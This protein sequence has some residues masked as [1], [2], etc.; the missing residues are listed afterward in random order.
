MEGIESFMG[1]QVHEVLEKLYND[2]RLEK[3][4]PILDDLLAFYHQNWAA[5]WHDQIQIVREEMGPNEYLRMG[6]KCITDYYRHYYPFNQSKT[7]GVEY[8]VQ[9]ALDSEGRYA[10][11]GYIDRLSQPKEGTL[12]IHD[13]KAKSHLPT[14]PELDAD[15]QL[16][17]YQIAAKVLW[18]EIKEVVLIWHYLLFDMEFHSRRTEAEL[19]ALRNETIA[20][21]NEIE[22]ATSFSTKQ[23][24][25][26][27]WCEYRSI[28]PLFK[29]L[30]ET[31]PLPKN[32]YL[33]E[34]GV[35]LVGHFR[36]LKAEEE[37]IKADLE[38][39]KE[40]LVAYARKKGV[41]TLYDKTHKIKVRVYPNIHFPGKNDS[42]RAELELQVKKGGVW[43]DVATLDTFVL[44]KKLLEGE[45]PPDLIAAIK[46]RGTVG[47]NIWVKL[48]ARDAA[49]PAGKV[50]PWG[51]SR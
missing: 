10:M 45:W 43:N 41:E 24:A 42:G 11:Q 37:R 48:D 30:Y 5:K 14:Q 4:I 49:R 19:D 18:P 35:A 39:V 38:R 25:L 36:S 21:I 15:R 16:A 33:K 50:G 46:A 13:Y 17:F 28:C 40:A 27:N 32:D 23:S 6:E 9:F 29:H 22:T 44:S 8:R 51:R 3:P 12:W 47:E 26:C 20:L 7:L 31:A 1:S 2:I 34:E